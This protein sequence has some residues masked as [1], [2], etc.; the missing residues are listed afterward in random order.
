MIS[1]PV[2][3]KVIIGGGERRGPLRLTVQVGVAILT[4]IAP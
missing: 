3:V 2:F 1:V 4:T